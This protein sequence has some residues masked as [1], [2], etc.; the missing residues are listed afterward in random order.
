MF[1]PT[2]GICESVLEFIFL[3]IYCFKRALFA[4]AIQRLARANTTPTLPQ[5]FDK[6]IESE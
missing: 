1:L 6:L 2:K 3:N 5:L 4:V